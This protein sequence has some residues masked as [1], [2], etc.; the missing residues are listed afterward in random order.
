LGIFVE[1]IGERL[2][3]AS[4]RTVY[5]LFTQG[6]GAVL[7]I[8]LDPIFIFGFEPLGI[9]PMGIAGAAVATVSGQWV[10]AIMALIFNFTRNPDVRLK[11]KYMLPRKEIVGKILTVG[12]PS[13]IMNG[14]G[15]FMNFGMNQILQSFSETA[16]SVFGIYFK[17]QSFF[18]MP[19]FGINNA[20][21]SIIAF[22]YGARRPDRIVKTQT[23]AVICALVLMFTGLAVFQLAPDL[24][25]N[26]FNPSEEFLRMGR[27]ALRTIS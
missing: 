11:L 18:F 26:L 6:L 23:L 1:I 2:L 25:L 4:G 7:N 13:I 10:A 24:A 14:I 21:I 19:L 27:V 3:Q 15:S 20:T 12:V 8:I 22:N 5:T 16:T 9:A 17:I